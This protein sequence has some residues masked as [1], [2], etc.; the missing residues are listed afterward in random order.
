MN[1]REISLY[2]VFGGLTTLISIL[3]YKLFLILGFHYLIATTLSAA[4][5]VMFAFMTNRM[6]VFKSSG[7]IVSESIKFLSGRVG[8]FI[9]ETILLIILVSWVKFDEFYSK[10][11][12]T[13]IVVL[14][15][16]IYSKFFVF[17]EGGRSEE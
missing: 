7:N 11:I 10:I 1:I 2:S 6:Y 4:L 13:I 3:S 17:T 5:A 12:V 16:Y 15:N 9:I 14:L 8:V